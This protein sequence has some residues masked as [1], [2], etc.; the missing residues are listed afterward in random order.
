MLLSSVLE[1]RKPR[2]LCLKP[3][4]FHLT[5]IPKA[6]L[7]QSLFIPSSAYDDE[8]NV[9]AGNAFQTA[10]FRFGHSQISD[11]FHLA[12]HSYRVTNSL[13][14]SEV[15]SSSQMTNLFHLNSNI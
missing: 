14:F 9:D 15:R 11:Q 12:D 10:A 3:I 6:I 2:R 4:L 1:S 5:L 13:K 8:V 7:I